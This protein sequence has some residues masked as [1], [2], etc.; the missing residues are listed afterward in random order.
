M[1]GTPH[2]VDEVLRHMLEAADEIIAFVQGMDAKAFEADR[3]TRNAAVRS[4]EVIGEAARNLQR[5]HPEFVELHPNLPLRAAAG[6]RNALI[7]G[8]FE[9]DWPQVWTTVVRDIPALRRQVQA[10]L[11]SRA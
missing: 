4:L 1:K 5:H 7:H 10:L 9:V 11:V 3:K 8:Y 2:S 6:M